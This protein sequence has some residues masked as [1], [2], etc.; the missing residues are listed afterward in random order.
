MPSI[1]CTVSGSSANGLNPIRGHGD[2]LAR[3]DGPPPRVRPQGR[4]LSAS[5]RVASL[6]EVAAGQPK[7][8]DDGTCIVLVPVGDAVYACGGVR[9]HRGGPLG[10]D[11]LQ[12]TR[13]ICP[14]HGWMYA[15]LHGR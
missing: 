14:W 1:S 2:A 13:L 9:A 15:R 4:R 3:H 8:V 5:R 6:D 11:K 10:Q 7:L 12:G